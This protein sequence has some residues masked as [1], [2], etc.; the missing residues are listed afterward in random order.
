MAEDLCWENW[1]SRDFGIDVEAFL[2]AAKAVYLRVRTEL[3]PEHAGEIV[4]IH[5]GSGDHFMGRTLIEAN[6]KAFAE[7]PNELV[8]FVRIGSSAV[9]PMKTW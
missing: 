4:A 2:V 6:A 7:H 9:M 1:N 5:P 3:E 8:C